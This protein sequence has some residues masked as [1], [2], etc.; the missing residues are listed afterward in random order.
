MVS[1]HIEKVEVAIGM[2]LIQ[3]W[4]E[5]NYDF[6]FEYQIRETTDINITIHF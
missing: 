5:L 6:F 3:I 4:I 1:A 2:Q